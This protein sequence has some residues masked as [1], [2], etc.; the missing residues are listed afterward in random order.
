MP[1]SAEPELTLATVRLNPDLLTPSAIRKNP[2]LL[3]HKMRPDETKILPNAGYVQEPPLG[4]NREVYMRQNYMYGQ[5]DP[6]SWPQL[7]CPEYPHFAC[8]KGKSHGIPNNPFDI[9]FIPLTPDIFFPSNEASLV[10]NLSKL[11]GNRLIELKSTCTMI[12]ESACHITD[13]PQLMQNIISHCEVLDM[14]LA[15]MEQLPM[16]FE[17]TYLALHETQQVA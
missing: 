11:R 5:D 2:K 13:P 10:R 14:F 16:S 9:L 6:L 17:R 1:N 7:F 12:I 4:S 3:L 8:I 15:C